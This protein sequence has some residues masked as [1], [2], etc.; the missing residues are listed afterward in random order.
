[1]FLHPLSHLGGGEVALFDLLT[2]LDPARYR[3]HL[4]LP[5]EGPLAERLRAKNIPVTIIPF[6]RGLI[7]GYPPGLTLTGLLRMMNVARRLPAHLVFINDSY[8]CL[9]GGIIARRLKIPAVMAS[10]GWWDVHFFHQEILHRWLGYP[11]LAVSNAV[12]ES[13]LRRGWLDPNK[14]R[15]LYL[16]VDTQKF[17]PASKVEA[18][19]RLGIDPEEPVL[20]IAARLIPRKGHDDFFRAASL[21]AK[22]FPRLRLLV[23][24]DKI[25]ESFEENDETKR[26]ILSWVERDPALKARTLLLGFRED[27]PQ[28]M[29]ATDVLISSA[30]FETFGVAIAEAMASGVPVVSVEVGGPK[31][32]VHEGITGFLVPPKRPDLLAQKTLEI[33]KNPSL[34]AR[35]SDAARLRVLEKFS[36]DIY[37]AQMQK[38]FENLIGP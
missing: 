12:R 31:E 17:Y 25:F 27:M 19:K 7:R 9:Y 2:W 21:V 16:G 22:E 24:G 20:T 14:V 38:I 6:Q 30:W 8:L 5:Q 34:A 18:K 4:V 13:L 23:V 29:N 35:M 11:I 26:Q 15:C 28:I 36:L 32:L 1:M 3:P 10:H 37:V 33:L